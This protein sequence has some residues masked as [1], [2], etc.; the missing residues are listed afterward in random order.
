MKLSIIITHYRNPELLKVCLNSV[1][2]N[3]TLKKND[4]EIIVSDSA[5]QEDTALMMRE[6]YP[7]IKFLP[8]KRNIGFSGTVNRG[9]NAVQGEFLL[10]MN[11]DIVVKKN[12]I[13]KILDFIVDHPEVGIA[14]PQ[15]LNFNETL[16]PSTFRFYTP[17]TILYRRTLLGK[18]GFA[19]KHL[20]WFM[21]K[22]FDHQSIRKVD[23]I[24]GSFFLLRKKTADLIGPMDENFKMYFEDTDWCRRCW[25]QGLQVVYYPEAK[26]YHYH[27]KGSAGKSVLHSLLFNRLTWIHIAS[28]LKFFKKYHGKKLV[29]KK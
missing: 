13:E 14:G 18:F 28:A 24:M 17:L 27:G 22:E 26:V 4:Y 2:K 1:L 3:I 7:E 11:G 6:E 8:E 16:Q 23:W 12:A 15:L 10:I 29:Q 9:L 19:K 25:E 20:D 5:T 21:M